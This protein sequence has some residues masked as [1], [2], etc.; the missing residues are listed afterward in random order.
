MADFC[1]PCAER[2]RPGVLAHRIVNGEG[3]CADCFAGGN[4]ALSKLR[5]DG[6]RTAALRRRGNSVGARIQAAQKEKEMSKRNCV[7]CSQPLHHLVKGDTCRKCR[8]G[9][10]VAGGGKKKRGSAKRNASRPLG[11]NGGLTLTV[12]ATNELCQQR[13]DE[14]T[15]KEKVGLLNSLS[16]T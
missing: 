14:L 13:W 9:Q 8:D 5:Q 15:L 3:M 4:A 10:S 11:T 1:K 12:P 7:K 6:A 2:G 16:A